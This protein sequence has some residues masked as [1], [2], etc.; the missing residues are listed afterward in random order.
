M[1][2]PIGALC[3][4]ALV[5]AVCPGPDRIGAAY[6]QESTH[7]KDR[8]EAP[9]V[10]QLEPVFSGL[11]NPIYATNAHDGTN[12]M[13]VVEK[14]GIIN[15]FQPGST[16]PGVFL[17]ISSRVLST[18]NEQGLLGLAFHPQYSVNGRFFVYY[19][20]KL[21]VSD[22]ALVIAEYRAT[23]PE[24][25]TGDFNSEIVLLTIP[26]PGQTNHNGGMID[27]G[28]DGYLYA[29]VGD[30][31]SANDPNQ[32]A[33]N[34]NA[35]LGKILRLDVDNPNGG[36]PYSSPPTNPFFGATPGADEI[37]AYGMR[38]PWRWAFDRT[39]GQLWCGD[40]GQGAREEIDIIT[41]GGNFG[42]RVMEGMICN[43][44]F[45]GGVCTP[46]PGSILP[47]VDYPH[48]AG[49][50]SITGG[51]VYRG[52]RG[53][54][55][56]AAYIY[57]DYCTGE[58]L[59][60][61]GTTQTVQLDT[62]L[63]ITSFGEDEAREVYVVGQNG[64]ISRIASPSPPPPCTYSL[65]STNQFFIRAGGEGSLGVI[66]ATGCN[67][68]AASNANWITITS[69]PLGSGSDTVDFVVRQNLGASSR[70]GM[71]RVAGQTLTITQGGTTCAYSVDT[72]V[73]SFGLGGGVGT[74]D[75][76]AS[77]GCQWSA[78]SSSSWIIINSGSS[79]TGN[80]TVNFTVSANAGP[81][82]VG[83]IKVAGR[84][85]TIKQKG[86]AT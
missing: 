59:T 16:T 67:W 24:S 61:Q 23:P 72:T 30:G 75:V 45:N 34:I 12:R 73:R 36:I 77:P 68:I 8:I 42:W 85:V 76:D 74:I 55:P 11:S 5:M 40:V 50:C 10:I 51:Y 9:N 80:G 66:C 1:W 56:A 84:A 31:G 82:R 29:G 49:R 27:F 65:S 48:S 39:T 13:F 25:N 52:G 70:V 69:N 32:N 62:S 20:R 14:V 83:Q 18:G 19:T 4:I 54:V 33:Q 86:K 60:L 6:D 22:G 28:A 43:P 81:V 58:I 35:L 64:T 41:N 26:H 57:A 47:V 38:N 17:N 21:P 37:Y 7:L 53:A 79:G 2:K 78:L 44:S 15:V 63:F 71:I 46:P 3:L